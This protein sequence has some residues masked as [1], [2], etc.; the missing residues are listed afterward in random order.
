MS[1]QIDPEV[2]RIKNPQFAFR[3]KARITKQ[4]DHYNNE[5]TFYATNHISSSLDSFASVHKVLY[6]LNLVIIF[7]YSFTAAMCN[8]FINFVKLFGSL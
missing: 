3:C 7:L 6:I 2:I 1:R 8:V 4:K 5:S